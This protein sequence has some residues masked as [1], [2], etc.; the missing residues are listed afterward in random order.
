MNYE[1]KYREG[2]RR[3]DKLDKEANSYKYE[4]SIS[5]GEIN[6][7]TLEEKPQGNFYNAGRF[8]TLEVC[9]KVIEIAGWKHW[10]IANRDD[11]SRTVLESLS[12]IKWREDSKRE[13]I[14][15]DKKQNEKAERINKL[16]TRFELPFKFGSTHSFEGMD[17]WIERSEYSYDPSYSRNLRGSINIQYKYDR[18]KG[19]FSGYFDPT[20]YITRS[21]NVQVQKFLGSICPFRSEILNQ[22]TDVKMFVITCKNKI[23][24]VKKLVKEA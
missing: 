20:D 16:P 12:V 6:Y 22:I 11:R 24:D 8:K 13:R 7:E 23:E 15:Y 18:Q 3:Q 5:F 14:E 17:I 2:A 10:K 4:I 19:D 9:Q 21:G 1:E